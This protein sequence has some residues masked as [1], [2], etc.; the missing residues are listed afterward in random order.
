MTQTVIKA[1]VVAATT[2]INVRLAFSGSLLPGALT[3]GEGSTGIDVFRVTGGGEDELFRITPVDTTE[4][5]GVTLMLED[6]GGDSI[7]LDLL[8]LLKLFDTVNMLV[9]DAS[10]VVEDTVSFIVGVV[11]GFGGIVVVNGLALIL[12]VN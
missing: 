8:T 6:V 9:D 10:L 7:S 4:E 5:I 11:T 12:V 2:M 3:V 1:L